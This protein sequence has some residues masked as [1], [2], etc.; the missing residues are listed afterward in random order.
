MGKIVA[1][2]GAHLGVQL[3]VGGEKIFLVDDQGKVLDVTSAAA[4]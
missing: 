2:V 3:D 1:A 4:L